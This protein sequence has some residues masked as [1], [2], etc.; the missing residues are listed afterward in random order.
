V[1]DTALRARGYDVHLALTGA[2]G[3]DT[4]NALDP[5]LF[6]VDL[7]LPDLDGVDVCR[8]LRRW[9]ANPIIVLTVDDDEARMVAALDAGA[10]DYVVK[11]F[12][13]PQLLARVRVASRHRSAL[14][15]AL[16]ANSIEVGA[17]RLDLGAHVA[18]VGERQL[19][20]PRKE[21]ALLAL[22]AKNV[23]LVLPHA[24]LLVGLWGVADPA[25]LDY[26]RTHVTKLRRKL[27]DGPDV[28]R[29]VAEPGVG[30]RL[31]APDTD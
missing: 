23:G 16:P 18:A 14:R 5:D 3:L 2:T 10:D 30:Y 11:P 8:H 31:L 24:T 1:L 27:G 4:A 7:S 6:I 26:L 17:L 29:I 22:L 15:G 21:F 12:S 19:R 13:M 20:L 25:R 28:P 9:T